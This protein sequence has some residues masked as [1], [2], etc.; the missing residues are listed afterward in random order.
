[1]KEYRNDKT[2]CIVWHGHFPW[3]R[4]VDRLA[5]TL[6]KEGWR[7]ILLTK[8]LRS[9]PFYEKLLYAEVFRV[10][11]P[12]QRRFGQLLYCHHPI[13]PYWLLYIYRTA[14]REGISLLIVR[15]LPL[16]LVTGLVAKILGIPAVFDMREN[17]P[18]LVSIASDRTGIRRITKNPR[19]NS[20]LQRLCLP[21]FDRIFVVL[22]EMKEK[23]CGNGYDPDRIGVFRY[24]PERPSYTVPSSDMSQQEGTEQ[25]VRFVYA[26]GLEPVRGLTTVLEAFGLLASKTKVSSLTII[27]ERGPER[28][29]LKRKAQKL[30][31]D[32]VTFNNPYPLDAYPDVLR[33][34]QVGIV[35]HLPCEHTET[36]VP[37]K[38]FEYMAAG[39]AVAGSQASPIK[40]VIEEESCGLVFGGQT[41]QDLAAVF[42]R[43]IIEKDLIAQMGQ[44]GC[45]AVIERYN[46]ESESQVLLREIDHLIR[47]RAR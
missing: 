3:N 43:F 29:K 47:T 20:S 19:L 36:T 21:L 22:P 1:M 6:H 41:A 32:N 5:R 18:A 35:N 2:V 13:N 27:A 30:G 37:M 42:R 4:G 23:L 15:D 34:F 31:L 8:N 9:A 17:Y 24:L 28:D 12:H 40:R 11:Y 38:L 26:G 16:A 7:V 44:N 46:W 25:V 33:T 14:K 39:L 45:R 10:P